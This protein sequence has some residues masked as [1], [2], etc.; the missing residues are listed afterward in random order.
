MQFLLDVFKHKNG[1]LNHT[2]KNNQARYPAFLDDY[3]CL[4]DA[5]YYLYEI[6][7]EFDWLLKAQELTEQVIANFSDEPN[8][9]F[10]YTGKEQT[11]LLLRKKEVYDGAVP[12]GNSVMAHN[13]YRLSIVFGKS[14][15]AERSFAM[16]QSLSK[17]IHQYP[18]SFGIWANILTELYAGTQEIV[19]VE[20]DENIYF[21]TLYEY[22]PFKIMLTVDKKTGHLDWARGKKKLEKANIFLCRQ[23]ACKAPVATVEELILL[24]NNDL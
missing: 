13:L 2:W 20:P 17:S 18:G 1:L 10:Y 8:L 12:S 23:F 3:A 9:F 24:I 15:W 5:L 21:K 11:D 7:T 19:M 22:L 16:V 6:T 4:I 14:G